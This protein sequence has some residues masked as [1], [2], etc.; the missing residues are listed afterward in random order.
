MGYI[1]VLMYNVVKAN[2][3]AEAED[4][5][6]EEELL[7]QVAYVPVASTNTCDP[8]AEGL[9][10]RSSSPAPTRL[11]SPSRR[12]YSISP[13]TQRHRK[14]CA[15]RL[16]RRADPAAGISHSKTSRGFPTSTLS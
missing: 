15:R 5:L 3:E 14:G 9:P 10:G 7:G 13:S 11:A 16:Q 12:S 6:T 4:K 1:W 2:E 8:A